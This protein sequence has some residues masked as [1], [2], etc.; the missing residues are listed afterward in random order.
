MS[1]KNGR[2]QGCSP[3]TKLLKSGGEYT[4]HG[5]VNPAIYR[6]STILFSDLDALHNRNQAYLYGRDGGPTHRALEQAIAT[7]EGG[8][9]ALLC[10]SGLSAITT[11]LLSLV[12]AGDHVLMTDSV[13]RPARYFCDHVLKRLGVET[14][15]YDP[16]IGGDIARL[17]RP[18]TRLVYTEQPGSQ[19]MEVQDLPAIAQAAHARNV[20]VV[21]DNTWAT[22]RFFNAFAHGVDVVVTAGTKYY[23][24][25]SDVMLGAII[26][27]KAAA[28]QMAAGHHALGPCVSPDDAFLVLRGLRTLDVRLK[29]HM[30]NG[31]TVA[32]WLQNRPE[33]ERVLYPALPDDPGH[34]LWARDF[35]GATGLFSVILKPVSE[36][37]LA[38]ML[39]GMSLFGMGYSWGGYES[40]IVPFDP[41]GYRTA[42]PWQA[43][44]ALRLHIGLEATEDLIADL[45]AGFA[46]LGGVC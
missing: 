20:L 15:Y 28:R 22:G 41:S 3:E 7:L 23:S 19:T 10:P 31:L 2:F 14:E 8:H 12:S 21:L 46:R 42:T 5:F 44:P 36:Q 18:N 9:T 43:A 29:Q 33:V 45:K 25:H 40:L 39:N 4:E 13:Y 16:L 26:A 24:G 6:G 35:T 30:A 27:S 38:N 1:N 17:I 32:R 11:A 34:G 37:A